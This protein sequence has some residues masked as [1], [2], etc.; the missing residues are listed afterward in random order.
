MHF[1]G[2]VAPPPCAPLLPELTPPPGVSLIRT[3]LPP[4]P[5][6][7][8]TNTADRAQTCA[9]KPPSPRTSTDTDARSQLYNEG[10]QV[11]Y[12]VALYFYEK[13][14]QLTLESPEGAK[15]RVAEYKPSMPEMLTAIVRKQE[16]R[17]KVD[18]NTDGNVSMLEYLLY[19]YRAFCNPADFVERSMKLAGLGENEAMSKARAALDDVAAAIRAYETEKARLEEGSKLPGVK[20]L[21]AKNLLAQLLSSP[22]AER[23]QTSLIKAEAAVRLATKKAMEE[24][25]VANGGKSA[26]SVWWMNRELAERQKMY[27]RKQ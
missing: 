2:G 24:A 26:G 12:N 13:L 17:E 20:G 10:N 14:C 19:Q 16:L 25:K 8:S 22:L 5:R 15:W 1:K 6:S 11:E 23:L 27:G 21:A 18:V 3:S 9:T 4:P 7:G